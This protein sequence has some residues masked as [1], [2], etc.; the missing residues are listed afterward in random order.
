MVGTIPFL[1]VY[2][3]LFFWIFRFLFV[4]RRRISCMAG[5][6]AA[7]AVGM[8]FGLGIGTLISVWLPDQFFQAT[9]LSMLIGG[10]IGAITGASIS[11]MAILDG[12]LSGI[13]GGMM[14]TMLLT[15]IPY[16]NMESTIKIMMVIY[17]AIIFLLF[18]MLQGEIKEEHLN[19][20][21]FLLS[22]PI[23]M[24]VAICLLFLITH[25]TTGLSTGQWEDHSTHPQ[26]ISKN[27]QT[28]FNK[29]AKQPDAPNKTNLELLVKATEFSFS[30]IAIQLAVDE[31]FTITLENDGEVEHDFEIIG[32]DIHVHAKPGKSAIVTGNITKV[33]T[34]EAICTLP[35]H[36]ETGMISLVEVSL[37]ST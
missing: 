5:M 21:S 29:T 4:F 36:K 23:S 12:L 8:T 26:T 19:K 37:L 13:M 6:M 35:G 34:Y 24:F 33:G 7:M 28:H 16:A 2:M 15:M 20:Q 30:P 32:T 14:G 31:P 10:L 3:I 22:K 9:M 17:S 25:Q 18:L 1:G 11:M 27:D